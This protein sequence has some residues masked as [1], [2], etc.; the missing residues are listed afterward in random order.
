M[1]GIETPLHF[2]RTM[3]KIRRRLNHWWASFLDHRSKMV[4]LAYHR[5]LPD[6]KFNP[7]GTVVSFDTFKRQIENISKKFPI[8]SLSDLL[9]HYR[10]KISKH[11]IQIVLTFDDGYRDNIELVFPLLRKKGIPATFL[12]AT[13]Y[14][15]K[16]QP[17]WDFELFGILCLNPSIRSVLLKN[18]TITRKKKESHLAFITRVFMLMKYLHYKDREEALGRLK[19]IAKHKFC[20]DKTVD[21]CMSW[22]DILKLCNNDME[23]GAHSVHHSSLVELSVQDAINEIRQCKKTIE[24][25]T[26]KSCNYFAFPYGSQKDFNKNLITYVRDLG[27]TSCLLNIHG[28]NY[29][30]DEY[31]Y[32]RRIIM[33]EESELDYILG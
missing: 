17:I 1:A 30:G 5:I 29:L 16:R 26:E 13:D 27:Y 18:K 3:V 31:L 21:I 2:V 23:I 22:D 14:I 15:G 20:Y 33:K 11:K 6:P 8:V 9:G 32:L 24:S 25:Y 10:K 7:F 28:Y 4:I 19:T 12:I